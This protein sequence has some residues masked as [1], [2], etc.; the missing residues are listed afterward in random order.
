MIP[1]RLQQGISVLMSVY[2]DTKLSEF[3]QTINSINNQTL[4]PNQIVLV[5]DGP[6]S[7][8]LYIYIKNELRQKIGKI[9]LSIF[10]IPYNSGLPNALNHGFKLVQYSLI[11][12]VDT[13]DI[14]VNDRFLEQK[15]LFQK[16]RGLSIIGGYVKDFHDVPGDLLSIREVPTFYSN[17]IKFGRRRNPLNHPTVMIKTR[18]LYD[19]GGYPEFHLFEDYALWI[20]AIHK[21]YKIQNI[22]K[23]LVYMR[24]G[25][26]SLRRRSGIKYLFSY[27]RLE[28]YFYSIN[29][30]SMIKMLLNLFLMFCGSILPIKIKS[31][32]YKLVL[33][34]N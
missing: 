9:I 18:V 17:I 6:I 25:N 23:V 32:I 31:L 7:K 30:I 26:N 14:L 5:I 33:R 16:D 8:E 1:L 29:Y 24:V 4:L 3:R 12:R 2:K 10:V 19:L 20:N 34:K 13:D 11:A 15:E 27:I 21:G 22:P 28:K